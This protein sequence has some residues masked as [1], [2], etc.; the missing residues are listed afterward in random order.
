MSKNYTHLSLVQRY[1]I[2]A[3]LQ[4]GMKQKKIAEA[5]KVNPSTISRELARNTAKRGRTAGE[6]LAYNAEFLTCRAVPCSSCSTP[7]RNAR[8]GMVI[9]YVNYCSHAVQLLSA[10][11]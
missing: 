8:I 4:L 7:R 11:R 5:I 6:Y 3:L 1:Q 2:E 10:V 9:S